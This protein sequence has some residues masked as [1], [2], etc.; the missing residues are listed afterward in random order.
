MCD[1]CH[2]TPCAALCPN[3]RVR[4]CGTCA[5]CGEEIAEG[6]EIVE[7]DKG[8]VHLEC[9]EMTTTR[10]FLEFLGYTAVVAERSYI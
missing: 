2:M 10:D 3:H 7:T 1:I 4:S 9:L 5:L 6:C 8:T